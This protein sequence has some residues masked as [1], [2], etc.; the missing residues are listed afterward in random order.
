VRQPQAFAVVKR[1]LQ[2]ALILGAL[3]GLFGQGLALAH[4]ASPPAA[5][6][7]QMSSDDCMQMMAQAEHEKKQAPCKGL[8]LDCIAAMGCTVPLTLA[9]PL[10]LPAA[11]PVAALAPPMAASQPLTARVIAPE[12]EPPSLI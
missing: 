8:T 11:L 3:L 1:V 7:M 10:I 2:L 4:V 9:E 12:L 5:H 6:P